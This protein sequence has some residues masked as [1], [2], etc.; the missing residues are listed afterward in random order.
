M[1]F[2]LALNYFRLSVLGSQAFA[3]IA[4]FELFINFLKSQSEVSVLAHLKAFCRLLPW[5]SSRGEVEKRLVLDRGVRE[6]ALVSG[7][8]LTLGPM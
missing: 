3:T 8:E 7:A 5:K 6:A 4:S 1:C 2:R